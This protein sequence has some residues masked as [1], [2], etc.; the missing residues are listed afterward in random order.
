MDFKN[1]VITEEMLV[2]KTKRFINNLIDLVPFYIISF[3]LVHGMLYLGEYFGSKKLSYFLMDLSYFEELLFDAVIVV[4]YF[5]ILESLTFRSLGKYVTNTK[6]I[7]NNGAEPTPKN[8]LIRSLCR[9][10]PFDALSFLGEKGKGWHDAFS[11]TYVVDIDNFEK[12]RILSNEL[13]Q[14]GQNI[15]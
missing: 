7:M 5:F 11:K 4:F 6:V 13:D 15:E 9:I 8:I 2:S 14:I 12:G 3:G 1:T 10:I